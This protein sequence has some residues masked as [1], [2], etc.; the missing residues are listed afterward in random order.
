[1][2]MKGYGEYE[3]LI[4]QL[5]QNPE[6]DVSALPPISALNAPQVKPRIYVLFTGS[7]FL[8]TSNLGDFAQDE[9]LTFEVYIV[10]RS[11]EG[12]RGVFA[13]SE[14]I[15]QR[16]LKWRPDKDATDN[17]T[18]NAFGYVDGIQNNWQYKLTFSFSRPRVKVVSDEVEDMD[19]VL[20]KKVHQHWIYK[21]N[22]NS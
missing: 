22:L 16:V 7:T 9:N 12:D 21:N 1:M 4:V 20:L 15:M 3:K 6:W 11:R 8:S 10:A 18:L 2:T 14:E 5:L 19:G 17:V 13:T